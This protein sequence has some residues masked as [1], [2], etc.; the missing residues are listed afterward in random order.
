[1]DPD[2]ILKSVKTLRSL[3]DR[4]RHFK[5]FGWRFDK[6]LSEQRLRELS[7]LAENPADDVE[8]F[9]W[10]QV[11]DYE[12]VLSKTHGQAMKA[13]YTRKA[14]R[15]S[16]VHKFLTRLMTKRTTYGWELLEEAERPDASYEMVLKTF[17]DEFPKDAVKVAKERLEASQRRLIEPED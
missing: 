5:T 2:Y 12:Q 10:G 7:I 6:K 11:Y 4:L 15:E 3:K 13:T 9:F 1:M 16:S 17:P 8:R 14:V